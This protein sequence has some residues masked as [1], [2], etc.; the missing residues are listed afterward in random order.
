MIGPRDCPQQVHF[1]AVEQALD[2]KEAVS[3]KPGDLVGGES[4]A[5]HWSVTRRRNGVVGGRSDL[6][7]PLLQ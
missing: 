7:I 3:L 6:Q 4:E 2:N 5:G 1:F